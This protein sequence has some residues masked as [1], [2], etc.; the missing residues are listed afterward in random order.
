MGVE[1]YFFTLVLG[2]HHFPGGLISRTK[3]DMG[4]EI[5]PRVS[6]LPWRANIKNERGFFHCPSPFL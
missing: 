4:V 6:S 1:N 5:G 3:K 2:Y